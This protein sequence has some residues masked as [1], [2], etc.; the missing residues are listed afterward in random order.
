[1]MRSEKYS[2]FFIFRFYFFF[3]NMLVLPVLKQ[4]C[5]EKEVSHMDDDFKGAYPLITNE[6]YKAINKYYPNY[7]FFFFL[8][9]KR[10][11]HFLKSKE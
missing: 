9:S 6:K 1:M 2:N 4:Y 3:K 11:L 10:V 7:S 5:T 8:K